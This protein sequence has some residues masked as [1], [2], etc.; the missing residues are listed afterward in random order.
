M[1]T[2]TLPDEIG[3]AIAERA[4]REGTTP[5]RL[6]L[7]GLR[8]LFV[9]SKRSPD[10][11]LGLAAQVYAGLSDADLADVENIAANRSSFF[12]ERSVQ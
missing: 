3:T 8:S 5:E 1:I 2:I 10:D 11:I 6:A 7:D 12:G 9:S 4:Q